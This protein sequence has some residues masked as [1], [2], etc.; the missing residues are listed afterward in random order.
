MSS[1]VKVFNELYKLKAPPLELTCGSASENRDSHYRKQDESEELAS[2]PPTDEAGLQ[3]KYDEDLEEIIRV[4]IGFKTLQ[5]LGQVLRNFTGSLPG[6]LKLRITNECYA[7]GMRILSF[8]FSYTE[9]DIDSIRQY[10]GGLVSER[11]GISDKVE[12]ATRTDLAIIWLSLM[13]AFGCI[14]RV[15]YAVG[16][17]DLSKTYSRVLTLNNN[18][19]TEMIDATIKLDHFVRVPEAEL[20]SIQAKVKDNA[21]A[22]HVMRD[23]VADY[24]YLYNYEAKTMQALGSMW[25]IK[26]S[27]PKML[28]GSGKR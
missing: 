22:A 25:N 17:T 11:T 13:A 28:T 15:S 9:Q 12:L 20:R 3:V 21:F 10:I 26:V 4:Q 1:N 6:D 23:L 16:H 19:A 24:L 14:K 5:I 8:I 2:S 18:L 27:T 7:L